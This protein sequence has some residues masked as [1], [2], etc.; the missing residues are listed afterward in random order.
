MNLCV[1]LHDVL[2]FP[3]T[4]SDTPGCALLVA[5]SKDTD[6]RFDEINEFY[7]SKNLALSCEDSTLS[8]VA[9]LYH[10]V[11]DVLDEDAARIVEEL[12]RRNT[13]NH[14]NHI[15]IRRR[16]KEMMLVLVANWYMLEH[17]S[18]FVL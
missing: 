11:V 13:V 6:S 9:P 1:P 10:Y 3:Q 2:V 4:A 5:Q 15:S 8:F 16:K 7:R 17:A 18:F 14:P 12:V